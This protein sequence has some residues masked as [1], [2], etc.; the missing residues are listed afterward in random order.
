[1]CSG[2]KI[3]IFLC[4]A[5]YRLRTCA[6]VE[7]SDDLWSVLLSL[8]TKYCGEIDMCYM[9]NSS[10]VE[11]SADLFPQPCCV[12]CS[13]AT[14]CDSN[15]NCCPPRMRFKFS[16][17]ATTETHVRSDVATSPSD[18][19]PMT[20]DATTISS[21]TSGESV[22]KSKHSIIQNMVSNKHVRS[23]SEVW[24]NKTSDDSLKT[25]SVQTACVR[26]QLLY[27]LNAHPD[28]D[29]FEMVISCPREF[30]DKIIIEKCRAGQSNRN[31]SDIIPMTSKL[32]GLTYVNK[33]C[34]ICNEY[35]NDSTSVDEW[36][37]NIVWQRTGY[38]HITVVHPRFLINFMSNHFCNVH[39]VPKSLT[40]LRKCKLYDVV[41]CNKTGWETHDSTLESVC[42][43]GEFLPVIHSVRDKRLLYKNIACVLCNI[44]SGL[45]NISRLRCGYS[46]PMIKKSVT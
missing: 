7:N 36:Q 31:I 32:S 17:A 24:K 1:M 40:T 33:Y 8:H 10:H 5:S 30:K 23:F 28:S 12:P 43:S 2:I 46:Y 18:L 11:P 14:T 13:C 9:P 38:S 42:N 22:V 27:R 15:L 19:T 29:A 34:L 26:P 41:S 37:I 16:D 4:L 45:P 21:D 20:W 35:I 3:L 44:H 25:T 6:V 39:F